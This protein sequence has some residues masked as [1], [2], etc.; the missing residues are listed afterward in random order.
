VDYEA[1]DFF[2]RRFDELD[3]VLRDILR[4]LKRISRRLRCRRSYPRPVAGSISV[5]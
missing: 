5:K 1:W 3:N 4:E 2:A